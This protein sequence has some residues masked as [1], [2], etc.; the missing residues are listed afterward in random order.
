MAINTV[1][2]V[3][4]FSKAKKSHKLVLLEI[5][6]HTNKDGLAWP[7]H[8]TLARK[9]GL[10]RRWIVQIVSDLQ[11]VGEL[12]VIPGGGP[13][14]EQAYRIPGCELTSQ[15]MIS[16]DEVSSLL[17]VNSLHIESVIESL[18][19]EN[20]T[21]D[22]DG[23]LTPEQAVKIGLTPG[24]RLYRLATGELQPEE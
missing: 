22:K 9:T 23:W 12:A 17:G 20:E 5:A 4:N 10:T 7:S 3:L 13:H 24:S 21:N 8:S 18:Y 11:T 6:N 16:S 15:G 14:G 19:P 1:L 2:Y